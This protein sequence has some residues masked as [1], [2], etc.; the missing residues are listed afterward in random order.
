MKRHSQKHDKPTT[1]WNCQQCETTVERAER[2]RTTDTCT[3]MNNIVDGR[4]WWTK[5]LV[6]KGNE[7]RFSFK[8]GNVG[9]STRHDFPLFFFFFIFCSQ[10][11]LRLF[12]IQIFIQRERWTCATV[13]RRSQK[14]KVETR[15]CQHKMESQMNLFKVSQ[16]VHLLFSWLTVEYTKCSGRCESF[17]DL[18][19]RLVIHLFGTIEYV[20]HDTKSFGQIFGRFRFACAGWAGRGASVNQ[21]QR[22][23]NGWMNER[24]QNRQKVVKDYDVRRRTKNENWQSF[25]PLFDVFLWILWW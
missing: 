11:C 1:D 24:G 7:N 20:D 15:K 22:L 14:E 13:Y 9:L 5:A 25:S 6:E 12:P 19:T 16:L 10:F 23:R 21:M 17:V 8:C 18:R 4:R 2:I 3:W